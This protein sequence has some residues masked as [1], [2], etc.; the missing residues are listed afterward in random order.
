[1]LEL[2]ACGNCVSGAN[3]VCTNV[4]LNSFIGV[5]E[6]VRLN[7]IKGEVFLLNYFDRIAGGGNNNRTIF[8]RNVNRIAGG[9]VLDHVRIASSAVVYANNVVELTGSSNVLYDSGVLMSNVLGSTGVLSSSGFVGPKST[10]S[11]AI[12]LSSTLPIGSDYI[13]GTI[14]NKLLLKVL[15]GML[16]GNNFSSGY[17]NLLAVLIKNEHFVTYIASVVLNVTGLGTS[18]SNCIGLLE[19]G[20]VELG[21]G[22]IYELVAMFALIDIITVGVASCCC[23]YGLELEITGVGVCPSAILLEVSCAKVVK[24]SLILV[25][26]PS[27]GSGGN[28]IIVYDKS[29]VAAGALVDIVTVILS[30]ILGVNVCRSSGLYTVVMLLKYLVVV[31]AGG[32]GKGCNGNHLLAVL[33]VLL[34]VTGSSARGS[35]VLGLFLVKVVAE[36]GDSLV[37]HYVT[38]LTLVNLKT[39]LVAGNFL[40]SDKNDVMSIGVKSSISNKRYYLNRLKN[41]VLILNAYLILNTIEGIIICGKVGNACA[42]SLVNGN[43]TILIGTVLVNITEGCASRINYYSLGL[44]AGGLFELSLIPTTVVTEPYAVAVVYTVNSAVLGNNYV[45]IILIM[46]VLGD[47]LLT[48]LTLVCNLTAGSGLLTVN[49]MTG[50]FENSILYLFDLA[51]D[52]AILVSFPKLVAVV[53]LKNSIG[54]LIG[55]IGSLIRYDLG[56]VDILEAVTLASRRCDLYRLGV[57]TILTGEKSIAGSYN[58]VL[59]NGFYFNLGEFPIV[60]SLRLGLVVLIKAVEFETTNGTLIES[61]A[62]EA[63]NVLGGMT[64]VPRSNL[65]FGLAAD[66][67]LNVFDTIIFFFTVKCLVLAVARVGIIL[68]SVSKGL[69]KISQELLATGVTLVNSVTKALCVVFV[70]G[71]LYSLNKCP[72]TIVEG[73]RKL[74]ILGNSRKRRR[75]YERQNNDRSQHK[76]KNLFHVFFLSKKCF[77]SSSCHAFDKI[78]C[79]S[80]RLDTMPVT[81]AYQASIDTLRHSITSRKI[82]YTTFWFLSIP[83]GKIIGKIKKKTH[84][85]LG[86]LRVLFI[87]GNSF[88]LLQLF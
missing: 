4:D 19:V 48:S 33:T 42:G 50:S 12:V 66:C 53:T 43:A 51:K 13:T 83:F 40:A 82:L 44:M 5:G 29:L 63:G 60:S 41:A 56:A 16:V 8:N 87:F 74:T 26:K 72:F 67:T 25:S 45:R 75:R 55:T 80:L 15:A 30:T 28:G 38:E 23:A 2:S 11:L 64:L 62:T 49:S 61:L 79:R 88:I 81:P 71:R 1:M 47:G 21:S 24:L 18:S 78:L 86:L 59:D 85:F 31:N 84:R 7:L 14:V 68:P 35:K 9:V 32:K 39:G 46:V 65:L 73:V 69:Y 36:S 76:S 3:T 27:L 10:A 54:T 17:S 22:Y 70:A 34:D 37:R 58:A 57:L 52:L 20:V 6:I 77:W